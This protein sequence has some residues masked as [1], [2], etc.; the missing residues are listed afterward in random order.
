MYKN[1]ILEEEANIVTIIISK[2]EKLNALD[3]DLLRELSSAFDSI[4]SSTRAVFLKGA[5]D[6]AFVAGADVEQMTKLNQNEIT[7]FVD[8]GQNLMNQIEDFFCPVVAVVDGYALG[9]GFELALACDFILASERAQFALPEVTLGL[10]PGFGGSQRIMK[11]TSI[12]QAK[13]LVFTGARVKAQEAYN[14][15]LID[16]LT[17]SASL[18]EELEKLVKGLLKVAPIS[19]QKSKIVMNGC[20]S[21]EYKKALKAERD[22]FV[23]IF[24]T[25]DCKEGTSA[26]VEKRKAEFVGK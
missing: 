24:G 5:G 9:G 23:E 2:P 1:L 12:G 11:R 8:L 6:K 15:G 13:R 22:A 20:C 14:L 26:F 3:M 10:M 7:E 21:V 18:E 16:I 19:V 25:D 4:S 17:D